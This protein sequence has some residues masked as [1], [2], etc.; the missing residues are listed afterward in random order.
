MGDDEIDML[1][2]MASTPARDA[3]IAQEQALAKA[4]QGGG[5]MPMV[6]IGA[7]IIGAFFLMR[8]K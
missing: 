7:A 4:K 3:R 5:M 6:L 2:E 1:P 8:K